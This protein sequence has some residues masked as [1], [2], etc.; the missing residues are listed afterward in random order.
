MRSYEV[1]QFIQCIVLD[2]C[3]LLTF[4]LEWQRLLCWKERQEDSWTR[5]RLTVSVS[6]L[7]RATSVCVSL[8]FSFGH[9]CWSSPRSWVTSRRR[10][11]IPAHMARNSDRICPK[12]IPLM[13]K[14][15]RLARSVTANVG[16]PD[17]HLCRAS[18]MSSI[19][20]LSLNVQLHD[21]DIAVQ[22]LSHSFNFLGF[23]V[24]STQLN[25]C[26]VIHVERL[27]GLAETFKIL[28]KPFSSRHLRRIIYECSMLTIS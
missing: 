24:V 12:S 10:R 4:L 15:G 3:F 19:L 6:I 28:K 25:Q 23:E 5:P 27:I 8:A 22:Q 20:V 14:E 2:R 11:A 21:G 26:V 7:A 1:V 13:S 9:P 16:I 17:R 18:R